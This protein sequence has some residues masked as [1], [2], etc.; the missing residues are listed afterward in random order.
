MTQKT[1]RDRNIVIDKVTAMIRNV[2]SD[3][4]FSVEPFG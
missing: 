4:D 1:I 2:W 3:L